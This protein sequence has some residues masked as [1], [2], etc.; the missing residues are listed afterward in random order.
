MGKILDLLVPLHRCA[1]DNQ[2]WGK[3]SQE[4]P[5]STARYDRFGRVGNHSDRDEFPL[6]CR[7]STADRDSLGTNRQ[8]IRDIFD[9]AADKN[10]AR[11]ALN[12]RSNGKVRIR[13]VSLPAR[14]GCSLN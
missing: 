8:P 2:I 11:F 3:F 12:S 14:F 9:I 5:A 10:I 7:D 1:N 4:L 6:S 13:R